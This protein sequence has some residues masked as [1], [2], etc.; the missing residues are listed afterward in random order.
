[1]TTRYTIGAGSVSDATK[2]DGG[3]AVPVGGDVLRIQHAM[4]M[5]SAV[6]TEFPAVGTVPFV[7]ID[8]AAAGGSVPKLTCSGL[9]ALT[10]RTLVV[11]GLENLIATTAAALTIT[12]SVASPAVTAS[13]TVNAGWTTAGP[14]VTFG[15]GSTISCGGSSLATYG[16]SV[17]GGKAL[18]CGTVVAE[19]NVDSLAV[20][21]EGTFTGNV[22]GSSPSDSGA[23]AVSGT[24]TGDIVGV[25]VVG[26]GVGVSGTV[27]GN[28]T[29]S[30]D[31]GTGVDCGTGCDIT[32]NT[33]GT[34]RTA[35]GV[36]A[37]SGIVKG[38]ITGS[39]TSG[40][41]VEVSDVGAV[42]ADKIVA[43]SSSNYA[44]VLS[45]TATL[46]DGVGAAGIDLTVLR[47]D[48]GAAVKIGA[49][50]TMTD[51][52]RIVNTPVGVTP[53]VV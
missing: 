16:L 32:G 51:E 7:S 18:V 35:W 5:A 43:T 10:I 50:V 36:N 3:V 39:S 48:G 8:L 15:A 41:G 38:N 29:G 37:C 31:T 42:Q 27:V 40:I 13:T 34:S 4:T 24:V 19:A 12:G 20:N 33:V 6:V 11:T 1:M 28:I 53:L 47:L 22:T 26:A 52:L 49:G 17:A 30:S 46:A 21:I 9:G 23:V 25:G 14:S 45:N 2:W 44:F